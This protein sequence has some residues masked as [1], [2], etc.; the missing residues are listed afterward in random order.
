MRSNRLGLAAVAIGCGLTACG[1][2]GG[3]S[4]NGSAAAG[5][6]QA[7]Q[8]TALLT[9]AFGPNPKA[10]SGVVSGTINIAVRGI[11]RFAKPIALTTSGPFTDAGAT[12]LPDSDQQVSIDGYGAGMTTSADKVFFD[13]G[14]AAYA[15]P[16]AQVGL[17]TQ[18]A[19]TAHNG[20]MRAVGAFDIRPD[21]WVKA[22]RLVGTTTLAGVD[23]DHISAGIDTARVF[24]DASRF[25]HFL[26]SLQV[27]QLAGLPQEIG[28]AAQAALVRSVTSAGG[29]LYIGASDHVLRE[30]R[31][32]IAL[33]MSPS[34]RKLLGGIAG[35]S[36]DAELDVSQVDQPQTITVLSQRL[37]YHDAYLLLRGAA[38][39]NRTPAERGE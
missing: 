21:L 9:E 11:P 32:H 26:T 29:D 15:V 24:L 6:A 10:V 7:R 28:P 37:P 2:G 35:L 39:K 5:A 34:D 31:M 27:T 4:G 16:R 14:T 13:I 33:T 17:M 38:Y 18:A 25:T 1:G 30:A 36:V 12:S 19:S 8:T 23:V 3:A 22:P 20:L